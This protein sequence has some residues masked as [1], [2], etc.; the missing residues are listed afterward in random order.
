MKKMI[1]LLLIMVL[2]I[3]LVPTV[4][5]QE[6][7]VYG[8]VNADGNINAKDAL[9]VLKYA[10]NKEQ[11]TAL[12]LQAANVTK[13]ETPNAKDALHI[14]QKSV[15]K[16]Q[17]F[18]VE[19]ITI[20]FSKPEES[21]YPDGVPYDD[22]WKDYY[23]NNKGPYVGGV[24]YIDTWDELNQ[25]AQTYGLTEG[26]YPQEPHQLLSLY[27]EDYFQESSLILFYG[28]PKYTG[29]PGTEVTEIY[30][31]KNEL[32]LEVVETLK[33]G[34]STTENVHSNLYVIELSDKF[35]EVTNFNFYV[36]YQEQRVEWVDNKLTVK[37]IVKEYNKEY[38]FSPDKTDFT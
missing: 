4:I 14:L 13:Q 5:A 22:F 17:H 27:P 35:S 16:R 21:V 10:V 33:T 15:G 29:L 8:D 36:T 24:A 31:V 18:E 28:L 23:A 20:A 6:A 25:Y 9:L 26:H 7:V 2:S 11:F 32:F 38:H 3:S 30:R 37:E 34:I 1:C 19:K 12:Q